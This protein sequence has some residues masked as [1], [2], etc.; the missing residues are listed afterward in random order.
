MKK[1]IFFVFAIVIALNTKAQLSNDD[2]VNAIPITIGANGTACVTGTTVNAI[3]TNFTGHACWPLLQDIPEVWYTYIVTGDQNVVT[4]TPNG[5][6]PAQQVAVSLT[7][8]PCGSGALSTCDVAN[9]NGAAATANYIYAVGTQVWINV[10]SIVAQGGFQ[11]CI[12]STTPPAAP[13]GTCP[14]AT[15]LCDKNP[16][17]FC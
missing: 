16:R 11:V 5:G 13:G 1:I 15:V 17:F 14:T 6:T 4:V 2:C 10:G 9:T 3:P 8:Q 12:S 7:N